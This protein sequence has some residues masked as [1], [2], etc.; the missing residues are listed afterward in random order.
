[1]QKK[2]TCSGIIPSSSNSIPTR[3]IAYTVDVRLVSFKRLHTLSSTHVPYQDSLVH[4]LYTCT[5][6]KRI[7]QIQK[8]PHPGYKSI[9]RFGRSQVNGHYVGRVSVETLQQLSGFDVPQCARRVTAPS[10][11]LLIRVRKQTTTHV[12]G[13]GSYRFFTQRHVLVQYKRVHSYFIV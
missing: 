7:G 13:M 11:N 4:T 9:T 12:T 5:S 6:V 2:N 1:M 10:Q 8:N 3:M